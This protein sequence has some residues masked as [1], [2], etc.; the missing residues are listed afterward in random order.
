MPGLYKIDST[1]ANVRQEGDILAADWP[2]A[3]DQL[4]PLIS[5]PVPRASSRE[6]VKCSVLVEAADYGCWATH[7][8][9]FSGF[10]LHL[11]AAPRDIPRA[12]ELASAKVDRRHVVLGLLPRCARG[13][14]VLLA[15]KGHAGAEFAAAAGDG[16]KWTATAA[17]TVAGHRQGPRLPA[18]GA[19]AHRFSF[20]ASHS[21]R[22]SA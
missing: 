6:A 12:I 14:E 19:L 9:Y 5:T 21:R 7:S 18:W 13:A 22:P 4:L 15:D 10:R 11:L 17:V 8:R 3:V 16:Q 20:P 1:K 2:G